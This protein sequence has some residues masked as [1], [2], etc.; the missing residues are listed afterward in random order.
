VSDASRW[1]QRRDIGPHWPPNTPEIL[2]Q[3]STQ[4]VDELARGNDPDYGSARGRPRDPR[5]AQPRVL[6]LVLGANP[7]GTVATSG[8]AYRWELLVGSGGAQARF[9]VDARP[10]QQVSVS[11]SSVRISLLA[12]QLADDIGF[13]DPNQIVQAQALVGVGNT[14]TER[15]TYT[16]MFNALPANGAWDV[17]VPPG[18]ASYRLLGPTDAFTTAGFGDGEFGPFNATTPIQW[19]G[20]GLLLSGYLGSEHPIGDF[21]LIPGGAQTLLIQNTS[22]LPIRAGV[23]WGLDL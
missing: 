7:V 14:S 1:G 19:F 9:L 12:N 22:L 16:N 18:A 5:L 21:F 8:I 3:L 4:D 23:Q 13:G 10:L 11:A 20:G 6:N 15:A 17:V 2:L